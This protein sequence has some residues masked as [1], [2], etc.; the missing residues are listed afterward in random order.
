MLASILRHSR[1]TAATLKSRTAVSTST[2]ARGKCSVTEPSVSFAGFEDEPTQI[3]MKTAFCGPKSQA[4]FAAINERQDIRTAFTAADYT[5][6]SGN[7]LVDADGNTML[8]LF[9]QISSI[10]LGYNHPTVRTAL[11]SE[12]VLTH[13]ANRPALGI[14]PPHDYGQLLKDAFDPVA[15]KGLSNV[16]VATSGSEANENAYKLACIH[17]MQNQRGGDFTDEDGSSSMLNQA[18]GS[19]ELAILSFQRAFHGRTFGALS[20][21]RSKSLHKVDIPAFDWPAARF[22]HLKYPLKDN[23]EHNK[24]EETK[25][26]NQLEEIFKTNKMPIVGTIIEPVQGEGGDNHAS[27]EF[28]KGVQA[29]TKKYGA[30]F[31]VDEVQTGVATTGTFWAHEAWNLDTSP[32]VV[33]FSKK[34][35]TG[36]FYHKLE[37]RPPQGYRIFNTWLGDPIRVV[38]ARETNKYIFENGLVENAKVTGDYLLA[39]LQDYEKKISKLNLQLAGTR[40][41]R[42]I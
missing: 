8:D 23:Q 14:A 30:L 6:S 35:Q 1:F 40:Y 4:A 39:G 33:V 29:I 38:Q 41:I 13:A 36:G 18:P 10:A 26:L 11:S 37:T 25:C 5:R 16:V 19:P 22:P 9:M 3:E 27:P 7:Y 20:T 21:T 42:S 2:I 31:I 24:Q 17:Y 28:F 32:D 15:P 34:M 12:E